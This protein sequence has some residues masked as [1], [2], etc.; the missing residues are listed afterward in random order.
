MPPEQPKNERGDQMKIIS[1]TVLLLCLGAAFPGRAADPAT[2]EGDRS[3]VCADLQRL[4]VTVQSQAQGDHAE[5]AHAL[6]R[7]L[8]RTYIKLC[9]GT[10]NPDVESEILELFRDHANSLFFQKF[11][12]DDM[13]ALMRQAPI[14]GPYLSRHR[15]CASGCSYVSW[16]IWGDKKHQ[17]RQSCHN[18]GEAIDIHAIK[19]HGRTFAAKSAR[20]GQYVQCMRGKFYVI[21][22]SGDHANHAHIQFHNCRKIKGNGNTGGN[23]PQ[24]RPQPRPRPRPDPDDDM[25]DDDWENDDDWEDDGEDEDDRW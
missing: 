8:R 19:C 16:G 1:F 11:D 12:W 9:E 7:R 15:Q 21:Y 24:P 13:Q 2:A 5:E 18:S 23:R 4:L 3:A 10:H 25:D 14:L 6:D 17:Q 22:G 20:F